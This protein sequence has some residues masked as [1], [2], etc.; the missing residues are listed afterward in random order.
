MFGWNGCLAEVQV[1][2]FLCLWVISTANPG[3]KLDGCN[4]VLDEYC[5]T[6]QNEFENS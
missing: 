5:L 2:A 4:T 3:A 6:I 1:L